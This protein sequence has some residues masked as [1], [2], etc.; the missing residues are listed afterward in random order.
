MKKVFIFLLLHQFLIALSIKVPGFVPY[1]SQKFLYNICGG[2]NISPKIIVTKIPKETKSLSITIFDPDAPK[3]GGWWH[4]AIFNLPPQTIIKKNIKPNQFLQLKNDYG[5]FGYGGPC[6]PPGKP[7]HYIITLYAL[8][9]KV[10]FSK[11]TSIKN[12][13]KA[14]TP[15]IIKKVQAVGIYQRK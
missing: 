6:P 8:K 9:E 14:I 5:K 11:N 3:V 10:H 13:L 7:H 12:A 1:V 4:W 15:L 2:E